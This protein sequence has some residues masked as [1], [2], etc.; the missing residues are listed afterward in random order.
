MALKCPTCGKKQDVLLFTRWNAWEGPAECSNCHSMLRIQK[1]KMYHFLQVLVIG[2][3]SVLGLAIYSLYTLA[4]FVILPLALLFIIYG[5][6]NHW[7]SLIVIDPRK[8]G[9]KE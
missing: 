2:C 4:V 5:I 7:L 1:D 3:I 8:R 6:A 9:G